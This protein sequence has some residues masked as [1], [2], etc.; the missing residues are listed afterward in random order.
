MT[1]RLMPHW[2]DNNLGWLNR[3]NSIDD[4][5]DGAKLVRDVLAKIKPAKVA[6]K[7]ERGLTLAEQ[8]ANAM[9]LSIRRLSK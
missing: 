6:T 4:Q 8:A 7:P 5:T 9:R 3:M 1:R 2:P